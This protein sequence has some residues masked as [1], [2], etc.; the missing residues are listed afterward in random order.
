MEPFDRA[1][2]RS[3]YAVV[4]FDGVCNLCNRAVNFIIAHDPDG[5]FRFAALQSEAGA[6]LLRRYGRVLTSSE[7]D[8]VVLVEADRV[9]DLSTAALRIARRLRGP[10]KLLWVLIAIPRPIRDAVYRWIARHRY[11]WF[12]Q[13]SACRVPTPE[14][15]ARFLE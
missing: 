5:Y 7:P 2:I 13:A 6:A 14:L 15:Q 10:W 3:P 1:P 9:F 4:L 8:S 12:G 11:R